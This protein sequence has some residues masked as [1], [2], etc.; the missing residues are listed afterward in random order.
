MLSHNYYV[1]DDAGPHLAANVFACRSAI[2]F[3]PSLCTERVCT[4]ASNG[5]QTPSLLEW[6]GPVDLLE[7]NNTERL[8]NNHQLCKHTQPQLQLVDQV[9]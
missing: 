3:L 1:G 5:Y 2:L 8:Y 7:C 9:R 4:R 6:T